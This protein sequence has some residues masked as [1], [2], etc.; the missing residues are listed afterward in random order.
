MTEEKLFSLDEA[1]GEFAKSIYNGIWGLLD[2]S[3]R[4]VDDDEIM[5][6]SA[7]ASLYHW[8]QYGSSVHFQRGYW[9][10]SRVYQALGEADL[11]ISWAQKCLAITEIQSSEM[12]DFDLAFAQEGLAR[13]FALGG[14]LEK[15]EIHYQQAIKLGEEIQD[16]EDK[17]IFL[18]D[19]HN[20]DW[21][22]LI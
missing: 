11:A 22:G 18:G 9:M 20:G 21:Y 12:A 3:N 7:F 6:L 2:K 14:E 15:A 19:L 8:K 17:K 5:L 16:P 1:Q 4:S 13:A 10:I